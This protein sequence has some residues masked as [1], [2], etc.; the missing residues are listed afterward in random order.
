MCSDEDATTHWF[1]YGDFGDKVSSLA[2]L[3]KNPLSKVTCL[4]LPFRSVETGS[5]MLDFSVNLSAFIPKLCKWAHFN[6]W[7]FN[8]LVTNGLLNPYHLDES[9]FILGA[10]GVTFLFYFAFY[11]L[12]IGS[13]T[14]R[15]VTV[16]ILM[17]PDCAGI[18][19]TSS[20][21]RHGCSRRLPG[22]SRY[23][24]AFPVTPGESR[25]F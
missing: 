9:T 1:S 16:E 2:N 13:G 22:L 5:F 20:R 3:M 12:Y 17:F 25:L 4:R 15:F 11:Y 8:L 19:P 23:L 6:C 10:A 18:A 7:K 24:T 21:W 14:A